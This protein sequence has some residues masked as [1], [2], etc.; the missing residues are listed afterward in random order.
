MLISCPNC[1][2][3]I[4]DKA[5][6]CP[7]C[8]FHMDTLVKCPDCGQFALP[9]SSTC[10]SCGYPFPAEIPQAAASPELVPNVGMGAGAGTSA[11]ISSL[12]AELS[13]ELVTTRPPRT[14]LAEGNNVSR[15]TKRVWYYVL[16]GLV[17]GPTSADELYERLLDGRLPRNARVWTQGSS[18]WTPAGD[19][20]VFTE[21]GPTATSTTEHDSGIGTEA[22][23][24][25]TSRRLGGDVAYRY[26]TDADETT[27]GTYVRA[28]YEPHNENPDSQGHESSPARSPQDYRGSGWWSIIY[29]LFGFLVVD[30]L[31]YGAT[32]DNGMGVDQAARLSLS[33]AA[34]YLVFVVI[35]IAILT[36]YESRIRRIFVWCAIAMVVLLW[37]VLT[38]IAARTVGLIVPLGGI[39]VIYVAILV[40]S[41]FFAKKSRQEP[42]HTSKDDYPK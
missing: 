15:G 37:L 14:G 25:M 4:S 42:K 23:P 7:H 17:Y 26:S 41:L 33:F 21:E 12:A 11:H 3:K 24:P 38:A 31:M 16:N 28:G 6:M 35:G 5:Q 19:Y 8:G 13:P 29:G 2:T 22:H 40:S 18:D 36:V 9:G 1:S 32:R 27:P 34:V 10:P 30:G 39:D 20:A